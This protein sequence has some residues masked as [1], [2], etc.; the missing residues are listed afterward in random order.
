MRS[1]ADVDFEISDDDMQTPESVDSIKDYG[2]HS[3][4]PVFGGN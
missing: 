3:A 1:N 2:E 4:F